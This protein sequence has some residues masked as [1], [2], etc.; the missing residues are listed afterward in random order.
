MAAKRR[1]ILCKVCG[2]SKKHGAYGLCSL[3]YSKCRKERECAGC[4]AICKIASYNLCSKCYEKSK[5]P[6]KCV[7][8]SEI[9]KIKGFGMCHKCYKESKEPSICKK[10]NKLEQIVAKQMCRSCYRSDTLPSVCAVCGDIKRITS[11]GA[12]G[13]CNEKRKRARSELYKLE[14]KLRCMVR[15]AIKNGRARNQ[16]TL[17]SLIGCSIE[18]LIS[19]LG[20]K[21]EGDELDHICPLSQAKTQ[22]ELLKLFN[23]SNMQWLSMLDNH[24][25][26]N[27]RTKESEAK[28]LE[29]LNRVW[30]D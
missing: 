1:I 15:Y 20:K 8:C 14:S 23:Y 28:C 25:K 30:I 26:R 10:C 27:K 12:C 18:H 3:C 21:K 16:N 11:H 9:K 6:R 13:N 2:E 7:R 24:K 29:L 19:R 5:K 22:T 4:G 17:E